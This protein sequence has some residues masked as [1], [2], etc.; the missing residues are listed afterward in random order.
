[1]FACV[2]THRGRLAPIILTSDTGNYLIESQRR[3]GI[4]MKQQTTSAVSGP[5]V[6]PP[7]DLQTD[8]CSAGKHR[9]VIASPIFSPSALTIDVF[10]VS[11]PNA[12]IYYTQHEFIFPHV[13]PLE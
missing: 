13:Q 12:H 8:R 4:G 7:S 10:K 1:M 2:D 3:E 9:G 5:H 11:I 6:M